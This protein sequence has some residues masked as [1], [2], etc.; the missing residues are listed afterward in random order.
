MVTIITKS[1]ALKFDL[2]WYTYHINMNIE[3]IFEHYFFK[4]TNVKV[5]LHKEG[6]NF[7][8]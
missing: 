8:S 1:L 3:N 5:K 6:P 7:F 2:N 4:T